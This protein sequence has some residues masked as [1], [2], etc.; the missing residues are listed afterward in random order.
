MLK[1]N[2]RSMT[3]MLV[4]ERL[5]SLSKSLSWDA[6]YASPVQGETE[7]LLQKNL[8]K[9][10]WFS[11]N[12]KLPDAQSLSHGYAVTAPFTQGS[13]QSAVGYRHRLG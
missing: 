3:A 12:S 6:V 13:L 2:N 1:D 5:F 8:P 9:S 11:E 7:G 10:H 4:I